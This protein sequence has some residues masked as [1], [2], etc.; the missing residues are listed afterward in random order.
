MRLSGNIEF[1]DPTTRLIP[2]SWRAKTLPATFGY[3]RLHVTRTT[4]QWEFVEDALGLT[5]DSFS[6]TKNSTRR[7]ARH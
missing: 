6:I 5:V 3:G 1:V 7:G 4:L 2:I